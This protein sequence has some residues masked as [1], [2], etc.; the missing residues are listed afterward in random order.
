[1]RFRTARTLPQPK[2]EDLGALM[3]RAPA[4]ASAKISDMA[5]SPT[6][7]IQGRP[8]SYRLVV[9]RSTGGTKGYGWEILRDDDETHPPISRSL[10]RGLQ[11]DGDE[12]YTKGSVALAQLRAPEREQ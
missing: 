3:V 1:M 5:T 8:P 7:L 4:P 12:A 11:D 2:G 6:L 10:V 9:Q